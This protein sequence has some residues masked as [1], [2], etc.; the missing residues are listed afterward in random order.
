MTRLITTLIGIVAAAPGICANFTSV[1]S[2]GVKVDSIA[3]DFKWSFNCTQP[4]DCAAGHQGLQDGKNYT[5][6]SSLLID[7]SVRKSSYGTKI[8][9]CTWRALKINGIESSN[10][11]TMVNAFVGEGAAT[12]GNK[13]YPG[14][15]HTNT[16]TNGKYGFAVF[17][18]GYI[19]SAGVT[20]LN[21]WYTCEDANGNQVTSVQLDGSYNVQN[22]TGIN[23][24]PGVVN[25]ETT[26]GNWSTPKTDVELS[27]GPARVVIKTSQDTQVNMGGGWS[28]VGNVH[29]TETSNTSYR[30]G[31]HASLML[32]GVVGT[33]TTHTINATITIE[34]I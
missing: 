8:R 22:G 24:T 18:W 32:K 19:G 4:T 28:T 33:P 10:L 3:S 17:S 9:T 26:D 23:I 21:A 29:T 1:W 16:S 34:P 25:V 14:F 7:M 11:I 12:I 13:I 5:G 31:M 6:H 20:N 15:K 27:A 30:K 2:E